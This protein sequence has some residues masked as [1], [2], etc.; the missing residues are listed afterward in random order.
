MKACGFYELNGNGFVTGA[1]WG[2]F[3]KTNKELFDIERE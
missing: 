3:V 1:N 2:K